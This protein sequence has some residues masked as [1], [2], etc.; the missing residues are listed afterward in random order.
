M[1]EYSVSEG[2]GVAHTPKCGGLVWEVEEVGEREGR[3]AGIVPR[4]FEHEFVSVRLRAYPARSARTDTPVDTS[5][6]RPLP[7]SHVAWLRGNRLVTT[8]LGPRTP[9][10]HIPTGRGP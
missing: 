7:D 8:P 1:G 10:T 5:R 4:R 9:R 3:E 2:G 6:M